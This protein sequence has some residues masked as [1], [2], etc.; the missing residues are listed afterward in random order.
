MGNLVKRC[1]SPER[2]YSKFDLFIDFYNAKPLTTSEREIYQQVSTDFSSKYKEILEFLT[3]YKV[4]DEVRSALASPDNYCIQ[5]EAFDLV[6]TRIKILEKIYDFSAKVSISLLTILTQLTDDPT[7]S[8]DSEEIILHNVTYQQSLVK[9]LAQILHFMLKFDEKKIA[10]TFLQQDLSFYRR[11]Q[12]KFKQS[13]QTNVGQFKDLLKCGEFIEMSKITKMSFF[14]AEASPMLKF[15]S[16]GILTFIQEEKLRPV[17]VKQV[18]K[19]IVAGCN[20]I[21][22]NNEYLK[23]VENEKVIFDT[24][25]SSPDNS[26]SQTSIV[27]TASSEERSLYY[28]LRILVSAVVLFDHLDSTGSF[29]RKSDIDIKRSIKNINLHCKLPAQRETLLNTLRFSSLHLRDPSVPGEIKN[30]LV[31]K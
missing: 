19:I 14:Y 3:N 31:V 27:S 2:R 8:S 7:S 16:S 25:I 24:L 21:L 11:Q 4:G 1:T 20:A 23:K 22:T 6:S 29:C 15:V 9:Q 18:L 17:K 12:S 10:N 13:S 30:L 28:V 5:K 26:P